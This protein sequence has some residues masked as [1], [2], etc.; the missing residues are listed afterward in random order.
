MEL[1]KEEFNSLHLVIYSMIYLNKDLYSEQIFADDFCENFKSNFYYEYHKP[2]KTMLEKAIHFP[3]YNYLSVNDIVKSKYNN[4]DI[5][6]YLCLFH[7]CL[8]LCTL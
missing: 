7:N 3:D 4:K 8:K 5:F 2:I 1:T 6:H